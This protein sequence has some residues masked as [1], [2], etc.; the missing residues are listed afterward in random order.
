MAEQATTVVPEELT[1]V[2][3]ERAEHLSP[4]ELA[5]WT[6]YTPKDEA[7]VTK[8]MGPGAK[9]LLEQRTV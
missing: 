9:L 5:R 6:T 4:E 2:F 8:L 7:L 1:S 3:E